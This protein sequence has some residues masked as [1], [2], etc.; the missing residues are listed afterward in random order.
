MEVGA[1]VSNP[2]NR[3]ARSLIGEGNR[4]FAHFRAKSSPQRSCDALSKPPSERNQDDQDDKDGRSGR[5]EVVG[6]RVHFFKTKMITCAEWLERRS[7]GVSR[8]I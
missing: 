3:R 6:R 2:P 8:E 4:F 1:A 5:E 7:G